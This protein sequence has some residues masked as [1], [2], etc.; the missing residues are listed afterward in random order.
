MAGM[1]MKSDVILVCG[2]TQ[3]VIGEVEI[4]A[5]VKTGPAEGDAL[6][7][8]VEADMPAFRANLA[9]LLREVAKTIESGDF[10]DKDD[11][12]V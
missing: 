1:D 9:A 2:G 5:I 10:G 6:P 12:N 11:E 3:A 4:P 8:T 7:F